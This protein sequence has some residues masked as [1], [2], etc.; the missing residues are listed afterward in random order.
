MRMRACSFLVSER[1]WEAENFGN[2][3]SQCV[4]VVQTSPC[5]SSLDR[6]FMQVHTRK[7]IGLGLPGLG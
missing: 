7:F 1:D 4:A 2:S 5:R 3:D 6:S